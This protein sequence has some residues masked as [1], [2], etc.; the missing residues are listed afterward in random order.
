MSK[1]IRNK[2]GTSTHARTT[3]TVPTSTTESNIHDLSKDLEQIPD[4][5]SE[6]TA[7]GAAQARRECNRETSP[8][9]PQPHARHI[10]SSTTHS[11]LPLLLFITV[12][13]PVLGPS[14]PS[15]SPPLLSQLSVPGRMPSFTQVTQVKSLILY[16]VTEYVPKSKSSNRHIRNISLDWYW[17]DIG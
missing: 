5:H 11:T 16:R 15:P 12:T 2:A 7:G 13:S 8:R 14:T 3:P 17:I 10:L 4:C 9:P 1:R 6:C